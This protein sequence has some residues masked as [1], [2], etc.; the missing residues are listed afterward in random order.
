MTAK[1]ITR[2]LGKTITIQDSRT[3]S[4]Y[5]STIAD[6]KVMYGKLRIQVDDS[7]VWFEPDHRELATVMATV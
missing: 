3:G 2:L 6:A 1:E 7:I 4:K 5:L